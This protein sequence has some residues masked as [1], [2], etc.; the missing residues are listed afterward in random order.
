MDTASLALNRPGYEGSSGEAFVFGNRRDP[1]K[2]LTALQPPIPDLPLSCVLSLLLHTT[3]A[4]FP[5]CSA[6]HNGREIEG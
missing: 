3:P 6:K 1:F 5:G 4:L 2:L